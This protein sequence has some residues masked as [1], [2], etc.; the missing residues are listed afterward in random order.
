MARGD[1]HLARLDANACRSADLYVAPGKDA[2]VAPGAT[3]LKWNPKCI[4]GDSIDIYLYSQMQQTSMLPIHAWMGVPSRAGSLPVTLRP[5]W[6]NGTT[7]AIT[8]LHFVPSGAQPWQTAYPLSPMWTM[9]NPDGTGT[10]AHLSHSDYITT[11]PKSGAKI[12]SGSLAAAVVVPVVFVLGL[13][14]GGFLWYRHHKR[15]Q[16]DKHSAPVGA[17]NM[18]DPPPLGIYDPS[19]SSSA[20]EKSSLPSPFAQTPNEYAVPQVAHKTASGMDAAAGNGRPVMTDSVPTLVEKK[21]AADLVP[22]SQSAASSPVGNTDDAAQPTETRCESAGAK[23]GERRSQSRRTHH[24]DG[25]RSSARTLSRAST[26][27]DFNAVGS[28]GDQILSSRERAEQQRLSRLSLRSQNQAEFTHPESFSLSS[29][30]AVE[31]VP[32]MMT[33]PSFT[34]V[35]QSNRRVSS[36][37][38]GQRSGNEKVSAYLSQLSQSPTQDRDLCASPLDEEPAQRRTSRASRRLSRSLSRATSR[39]SHGHDVESG[40]RFHD[41]FADAPEE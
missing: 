15:K 5:E 4:N 12:A 29:P 35:D 40:T 30:S 31:E 8:N 25:R 20:T 2:S 36:D 7:T 39:S 34:L 6:W 27:D 24:G 1:R 9:S 26:A 38:L 21:G 11:Y 33:R 37:V 10:D 13:V 22:T 32:D 3:T 16:T 23:P 28:F 14:A 41:A 19:A 18:H 17:G